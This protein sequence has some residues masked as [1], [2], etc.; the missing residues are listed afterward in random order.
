MGAR[1]WAWDLSILQH[2]FFLH[3]ILTFKSIEIQKS[4]LDKFLKMLPTALN[5]IDL[6][7]SLQVCIAMRSV[8]F[9]VHCSPFS[10]L[11]QFY[12]FYVDLFIFEMNAKNDQSRQK[13][14]G[15]DCEIIWHRFQK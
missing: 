15:M 2:K 14:H 3:K 11:I 1:R 5:S 6:I 7:I 9:T 12:H 13:S 10:A 4:E 8:Q